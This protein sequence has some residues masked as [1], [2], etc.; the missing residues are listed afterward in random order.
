MTVLD[1][2]FIPLSYSGI[3]CRTRQKRLAG[4]KSL[5]VYALAFY[6]DQSGIRSLLHDSIGHRSE[7][8]VFKDDAMYS[9]VI[10]SPNVEKVLRLVISSGLVNRNS[11]LKAL[12]ERLQPVVK[13]TKSE[14]TLATFCSMFDNVS[15]RKGLDVTFF[16]QPGGDLVTRADGKELGRLH[17]ATFSKE[18]L[19]IYLGKNPVSVSAKEEFGRGIYK[20]VKKN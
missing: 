1:Y 16:F 7:D 13:D 15:F 2:D 14:E 5:N 8:A 9:K 3:A 6:V 19:N 20:I 17:D 11:F 4:I 18:I 10:S 12:D